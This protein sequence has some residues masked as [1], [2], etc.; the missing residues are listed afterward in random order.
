MK[1]RA[2]Q[3]FVRSKKRKDDR[4]RKKRETFLVS[5]SLVKLRAV[6]EVLSTVDRETIDVRD[7]HDLV[8]KVYQL[9]KDGT[10]GGVDDA[11]VDLCAEL[12]LN[13]LLNVYDQ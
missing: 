12:M 10:W 5:V 6:K 11:H 4:T 2:V 7:A 8:A 13:W 9:N 3:K 1:L